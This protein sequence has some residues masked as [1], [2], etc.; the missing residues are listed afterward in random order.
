MPS[1]KNEK[2]AEVLREV[3]VKCPICEQSLHK[4]WVD[5]KFNHLR[6]KI[7][8][9]RPETF[10]E[11]LETVTRVAGFCRTCEATITIEIKR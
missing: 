4:I 7:W 3:E 2:C 10:T 8:K 5:Q 1:K 9:K 11:C 6:R